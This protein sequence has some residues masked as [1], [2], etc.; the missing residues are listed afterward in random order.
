MLQMISVKKTIFIYY[1][2]QDL[3]D[4]LITTKTLLMDPAFCS[5]EMSVGNAASRPGTEHNEAF[6]LKLKDELN[7]A[8]GS[9]C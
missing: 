2:I 6:T 8:S 5:E 3:K 4:V 7:S 9:T 1:T